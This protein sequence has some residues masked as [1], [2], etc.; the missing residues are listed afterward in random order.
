MSVSDPEPMMR[1]ELAQIYVSRKKAKSIIDE[2]C[3]PTDCAI[4]G[5]VR[6]ENLMIFKSKYDIIAFLR[7]FSPRGE[8]KS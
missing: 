2:D 1:F 3:R 4:K 8:K 7:R 5:D 6:M